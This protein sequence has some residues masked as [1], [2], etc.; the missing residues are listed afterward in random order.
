MVR[1][2]NAL[3]AFLNIITLLLS[4]LA[5]G[6][7]LWHS[8]HPGGA[9]VCQKVIQ[10]PLLIAGL[11][12]LVTS[13]FGLIGSSCR[14]SSL[15]W[16]YL[17]FMFVLMV[18]LFCFAVFS[19]VVMRRG[20][21]KVVPAE[22]GFRESHWLQNY[23]A[24]EQHWEKIRSCLLDA[25]VC[26]S[27]GE[28]GHHEKAE[29]FFKNNLSTTESGCCKPPTYCGFEYQNATFWTVPKSGPEVPD[30]DCTTWSNNQTVLCYDCKSCKAGVLA[31]IKKEWTQLT[32]TVTGI[33][34]FI[35]IIYSVGCCA[36][37][38]NNQSDHPYHRYKNNV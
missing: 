3:I 36:L 33:L 24:N 12:L 16:I 10:Q 6:A 25:H 1:V 4:L 30:S 37:R 23:V 14:V 27:L 9:S 5:I 8:T 22:K 31:N 38:N 11:F 13:L 7:S 18:G 26:K 20:L 15:L 28:R 32:F 2:S 29:D 35:I 34:I 19:I 17:A 21:G